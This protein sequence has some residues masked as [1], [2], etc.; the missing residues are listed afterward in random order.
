MSKP[1]KVG[2]TVTCTWE[3]HK[4]EWVVEK[5]GLHMGVDFAWLTRW[6]HHLVDT[7][8]CPV[9]QLIVVPDTYD[10][11]ETAPSEKMLNVRWGK[12]TNYEYGTARYSHGSWWNYTSTNPH[13]RGRECTTPDGWNGEC[14]LTG[15]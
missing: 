5:L 13:A 6:P 1:V 9:S 10:P 15:L 14:E 7:S 3:N 2:D 11:I 12:P 8:Q 4:R